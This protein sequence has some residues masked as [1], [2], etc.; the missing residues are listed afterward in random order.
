MDYNPT[1]DM[2]DHDELIKRFRAAAITFIDAVDLAPELEREAFLASVSRSMV[3]LYAVAL[4]C[5][6]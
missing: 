3:E 6:R 4:F 2:T 5:R 1:H